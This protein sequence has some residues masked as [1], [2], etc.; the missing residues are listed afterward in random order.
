[1]KTLGGAHAHVTYGYLIDLVRRLIPMFV[2][3]TL[4]VIG[5][6]KNNKHTL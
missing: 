1:M 4:V 5:R 2:E 6:I 3:T